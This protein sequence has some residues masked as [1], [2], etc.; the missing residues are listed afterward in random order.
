MRAQQGMWLGVGSGLVGLLL[1]SASQEQDSSRWGEGG[2]SGRG[3]VA[4]REEEVTPRPGDSGMFSGCPEQDISKIC[5][6]DRY[7]KSSLQLSKWLRR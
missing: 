1:K 2:S 7:R 5:K 4:L 3:V 6:W